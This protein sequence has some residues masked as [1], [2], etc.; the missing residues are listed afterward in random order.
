MLALTIDLNK[1]I[2]HKFFGLTFDLNVIWSTLL[3]GL[4]IMIII[5]IGRR[6]LT[7][8]EPGWLQA[9]FEHLI[10][11]VYKELPTE[12][13]PG[14][15]AAL[16]LS[17]FVFF[18]LLISNWL[19]LIP[20]GHGPEYL[21]SPSS[22]VNMNYALSISVIIFVHVQSI[23]ARGF[24]GYI[25]HYLNP[26]P[27]IL[28]APLNVIEELAKPLTLALRLF[29][30]L[31][32]GSIMLVILAA[33]PLYLPTTLLD[34]AWKLADLLIGLLQAYIFMLLTIVYYSTAVAK[35]EH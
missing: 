29:G 21:P 26:K 8:G 9:L 15:N 4:I 23:R 18:Y 28:F 5:A 19:V 12:D 3:V 17:V 1:Y 14:K 24:K 16:S 22:N 20:S 13:T 2:T 33:I 7:E 34:G 10:E 30:N 32:A 11:Y 27:A 35:D 31:F 6:K 25:T